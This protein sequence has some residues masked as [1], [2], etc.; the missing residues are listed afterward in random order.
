MDLLS[1]LSIH[2]EGERLRIMG[3]SQ[4]FRG[5]FWGTVA[6]YFGQLGFPGS[7]ASAKI[8][9]RL[10]GLKTLDFGLGLYGHSCQR[11][12]FAW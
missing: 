5:Y 9:T 8:R 11:G 4:S 3:C 7:Y 6:C 12:N 1:R 2:L 10:R